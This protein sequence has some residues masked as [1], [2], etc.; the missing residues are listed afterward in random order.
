M[1]NVIFVA[2][3]DGYGNFDSGVYGDHF[4]TH[5]SFFGISPSTCLPYVTFHNVGIKLKI[6]PKTIF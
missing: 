2:F 1:P 3:T 4:G 5:N 6:K